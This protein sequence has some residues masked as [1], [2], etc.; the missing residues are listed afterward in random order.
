MDKPCK[1][2]CFYRE[3]RQPLTH[4][5]ERELSAGE[6]MLKDALTRM[7]Q[8]EMQKRDAEANLLRQ[9]SRQ[10]VREWSIRPEMA[11]YCGLHE[12]RDVYYV[13]ELKNPGRD[14][15]DFD[16]RAPGPR[17]E[18]G[19]CRHRVLATGPQRDEA[20]V[21]AIRRMAA[22][23]VAL[24]QPGGLG[25][26][27]EFRSWIATTKVREATQAF[28]D[29]RLSQQPRYLSICAKHSRSSSFVPCV[30]QNPHD[31]CPDWSSPASAASASPTKGWGLIPGTGRR[32]KP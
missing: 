13:A 7:S 30:V 26:L 24:D 19:T 1:R 28:Q 29:R 16:A 23:A 3:L 15:D 22:T 20:H 12:T 17:R 5:L 14:C 11:S 27:D 31:D 32:G 9:L 2:C 18:C 25:Q 21:A 8:E 6:A 4:R 10:D